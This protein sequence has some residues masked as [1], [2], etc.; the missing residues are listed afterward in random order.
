MAQANQRSP[1][2]SPT[3]RL[4]SSGGLPGRG[5]QAPLPAML[6]LEFLGVGVS[7]G[8]PTQGWLISHVLRIVFCLK[9]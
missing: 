9:Y 5:Q 7:Q 3:R 2:F 1:P 4:S 6:R 8:K